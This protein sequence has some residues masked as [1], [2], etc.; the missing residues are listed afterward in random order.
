[1][2]LVED[3]FSYLFSFI[4]F[5]PV[6]QMFSPRVARRECGAERYEC[7][8]PLAPLRENQTLERMPQGAPLS[9]TLG[10]YNK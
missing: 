5:A 7:L 8:V 1:L 3:L 4:L 9:A 6:K 10:K 2:V